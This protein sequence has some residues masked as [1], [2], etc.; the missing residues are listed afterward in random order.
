MK[1]EILFLKNDIATKDQPR[2]QY[3]EYDLRFCRQPVRKSST[4]CFYLRGFAVQN[5]IDDI[6]KDRLFMVQLMKSL[7]VSQYFNCRNNF[8]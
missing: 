8:L 3:T 5:R 1:A 4:N 2:Q 6:L 7:L